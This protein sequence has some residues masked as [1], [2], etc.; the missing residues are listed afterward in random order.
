MAANRNYEWQMALRLYYRR[1]NHNA[2]FKPKRLHSDQNSLFSVV[3]VPKSNHFKCF[4]ST[5][6]FFASG[7]AGFFICITIMFWI[8]IFY[9]I[10]VIIMATFLYVEEKNLNFRQN[11]I[12]ISICFARKLFKNLGFNRL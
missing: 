4:S 5:E 7:I 8:D 12:Q 6:I 1:L 10:A 2:H 3:F 11:F 9:A